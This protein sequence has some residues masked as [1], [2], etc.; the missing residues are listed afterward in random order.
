MTLSWHY[1]QTTLTLERTHTSIVI[2]AGN[3]YYIVYKTHRKKE[4]RKRKNVIFVTII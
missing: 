2:R 4:R 3:Y 1:T